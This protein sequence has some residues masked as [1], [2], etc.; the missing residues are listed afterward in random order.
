[1]QGKFITFEGADGGGKSTQLQLA[2]AFL[3][4]KNYEVVETREPGGTI[5]AEQ[6]RTIVLDPQLP[7]NN[8]TQTLLYLAAR[9]EHV[10]KLIKPA[11][12]AGKIVL[13]DRFSDSTLVYQ[14]LAMDKEPAALQEIKQFNAYACDGLTPDL[15]IL[16]DGDTDV[17]ALRR[18]QRGVTD[19]YEEQ[20][21]ELQRKLRQG[22]L[23]LAQQEPARIKIIN[24]E[25]NK[26]QIAQ[27]IA[28]LLEMLLQEAD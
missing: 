9:S 6:V 8:T 5:L 11:L 26:E 7:L 28:S 25:A 27:K 14:G 12:T 22:F 24:A 15:T 2:A 20:G 3:R 18:S 21:L 10:E 23:Q 17:L 16:L 4:A 19:R 1:M 13:C